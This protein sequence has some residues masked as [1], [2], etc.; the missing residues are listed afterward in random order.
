MERWLDAVTVTGGGPRVAFERRGRHVWVFRSSPSPE[1]SQAWKGG[2][3]Y[4]GGL[5]IT[6]AEEGRK[7]GAKK[8][9]SATSK[10]CWGVPALG[11]EPTPAE[12]LAG[13]PGPKKASPPYEGR[14]TVVDC[15]GGGSCFYLA[16]GTALTVANTGKLP[17]AE[18]IKPNGSIQGAL[19]SFAAKE[20]LANPEHHN[21]QEHRKKQVHDRFIKPRTW[22][23]ETACRALAASEELAANL[24]LGCS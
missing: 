16:V 18:K 13:G 9:P 4:A 10:P 19:R 17:A 20:I 11:A 5:T 3:C 6:P 2:S 23:C 8:A 21:V 22:G 7:G 24:V 1:D 14:Y 15:G 12:S